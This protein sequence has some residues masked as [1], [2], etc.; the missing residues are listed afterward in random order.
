M[1]TVLQNLIKIAL[2]SDMGGSPDVLAQTIAG[3]VCTISPSGLYLGQMPLVPGGV[4]GGQAIMKTAF[5]TDMGGSP[6]VLAQLIATAVSVINPMVPPAALSLLQTLLKLDLQM[7][8]GGSP[9]AMAAS[10]ANNITTY[11]TACQVV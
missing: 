2:I 11:F 10:M 6:D 5:Q 3:A 4:S 1:T 7:D 8:I 9:D